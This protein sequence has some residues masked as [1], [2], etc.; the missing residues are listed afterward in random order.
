MIREDRLFEGVGFGVD[1]ADNEK[2]EV[3]LVF[4]SHFDP[5]NLKTLGDN[6]VIQ[7]VWEPVSCVYK[8]RRATPTSQGAIILIGFK[9]SP[10]PPFSLPQEEAV[11]GR[12]NYADR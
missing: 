1:A 4:W 10:Y 7:M 5:N 9:A 11:A 6:D 2:F 12:I 3:T 8:Y